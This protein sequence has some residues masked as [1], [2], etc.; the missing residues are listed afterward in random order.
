[1]LNDPTQLT[2]SGPAAAPAPA[3]TPAP[4]PAPAANGAAAPDAVATQ[5][6]TVEEVE[7]EYK[8]RLSGKDRAHN[9]AEQTLRAQNEALQQKLDALMDGAAAAGQAGS[10]GEASGPNPLAAQLAQERAAREQA[11]QRAVIA[12]RRAKFPALASYVHESILQA[13][14]EASLAKLNAQLEDSVGGG[15]NYIA[16]TSPSRSAPVPA[17]PFAEMTKQ[18]L[19]DQLK[20]AAPAYEATRRS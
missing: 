17:K 13:T 6:R 15:G 11:E 20:V 19:L 18:E 3:A 10:P 8:A 5:G 16:P 12:D 14:D 2:P 9:V 1:M 7:A 4:V